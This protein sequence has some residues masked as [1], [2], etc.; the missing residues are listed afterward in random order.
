MLKRQNLCYWRSE[1][2]R[3]DLHLEKPV[4]TA[5]N[6][7]HWISDRSVFLK[8]DSTDRSLPQHVPNLFQVD[9]RRNLRASERLF[10]KFKR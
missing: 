3:Q 1:R 10:T 8:Q 7:I 2:E 4:E 6:N 5:Y 9:R